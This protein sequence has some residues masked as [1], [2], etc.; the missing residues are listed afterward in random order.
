MRDLCD[1]CDMSTDAADRWVPDT[2]TFGARLALIR[3]RMGWNLKEAAL[4]CGLP[5][6]SW[7]EWELRGRD[8]RGLQAIADRIASHTGVDEYWLITGRTLPGG[9]GPGAAQPV[10]QAAA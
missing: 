4:A 10:E 5:Q 3:Q 8:P 6:G 2:S 7:R 9:G 1:I